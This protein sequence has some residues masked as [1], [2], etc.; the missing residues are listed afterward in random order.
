MA[1]DFD[2][3]VSEIIEQLQK[4]PSAKDKAIDCWSFVVVNCKPN[5]AI[6]HKYILPIENVISKYISDLSVEDKVNIWEM[7]E[8]GGFGEED[9]SNM[10]ISMIEIELETELLDLVM[11]EAFL[12]SE[13]I[14]KTPKTIH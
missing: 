11:R 13:T 6:E 9:S 10:L 8:S 2:T 14:S 4:Q 7:T 12:E 1:K 5:C 3:A